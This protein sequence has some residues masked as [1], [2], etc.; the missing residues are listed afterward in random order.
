[1]RRF[2]VKHL[3]WLVPFIALACPPSPAEAIQVRVTPPTA[4]AQ[5]G[6]DPYVEVPGPAPTDLY[7]VQAEYH[8]TENATWI[9]LAAVATDT[10]GN[11][12][13]TFTIPSPGRT[14][15]IYLHARWQDVSGQ[16][17]CWYESSRQ[18][19]YNYPPGKAGIVW[20]P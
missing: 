4:N 1:M 2:D 20:L 19:V 12:G 8:T 16:W 14:T 11:G 7:Q 18:Y 17:G 9:P 6:C 13:V 5:D 10:L 15:V 3:I